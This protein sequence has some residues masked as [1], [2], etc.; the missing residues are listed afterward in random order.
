MQVVK[1]VALHKVCID[2]TTFV[3]I[4]ILILLPL[5]TTFMNEVFIQFS[6]HTENMQPS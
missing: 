1:R 2:N 4:D 3:H 6:N 5:K